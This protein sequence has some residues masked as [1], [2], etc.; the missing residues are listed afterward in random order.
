VSKLAIV[1]EEA[2]E[3][4]FWLEVVVELGVDEPEGRRLHSE[5]SEIVAMMVASKKAARTRFKNRA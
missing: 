1:E 4:M 5:A 2:D 3:S